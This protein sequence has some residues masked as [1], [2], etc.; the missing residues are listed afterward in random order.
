M[1]SRILLVSAVLIG[2]Q[3]AFAGAANGTLECKSASGRTSVVAS[4]PVDFV[5]AAIAVTVDGKT[6]NYINQE[7]V[8]NLIAN[9]ESVDQKYPGF[10]VTTIQSDKSKKSILMAALTVTNQ[11]FDDVHVSLL[12]VG[13]LK[14]VKGSNTVK[15]KAEL[16]GEDPRSE[17]K[18]L[19]PKI[20]LDCVYGYS[21]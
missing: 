10:K 19:L 12:S 7:M 11:K 17:G 16:N 20:T 1:L 9:S 8:D 5:E 21:I 3:F 18:T 2:P 15:F 14:P 13:A 6:Q 4:F